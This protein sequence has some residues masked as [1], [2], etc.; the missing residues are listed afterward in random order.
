ML[1]LWPTT[2][3]NLLDGIWESPDCDGREA[4][5][6]EPEGRV[7]QCGSVFLYILCVCV[8]ARGNNVRRQTFSGGI[9]DSACGSDFTPRD[10]NSPRPAD[11]TSD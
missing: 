8:L 4:E 3:F 9:N 1:L 6:T 7:T 11:S 5:H 2:S 10:A